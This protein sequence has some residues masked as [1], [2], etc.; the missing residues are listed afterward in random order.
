VSGGVWDPVAD[1]GGGP[2][3][4]CGAPAYP[5]A[6]ADDP[7]DGRMDGYCDDCAAARC[8]AYPGDCGNPRP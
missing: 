6:A 7:W 5:R 4:C 8:D 3:L 2:C 1:R